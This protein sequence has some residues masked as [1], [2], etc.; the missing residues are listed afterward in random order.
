MSDSPRRSREERLNG[1]LE[2]FHSCQLDGLRPTRAAVR[3]AWDYI[4]GRRTL[5]DLI[6]DVVRRHTRRQEY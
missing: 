3:D 2:A 5:D 1:V 4:E 6:E